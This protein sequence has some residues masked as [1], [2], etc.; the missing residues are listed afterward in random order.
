MKLFTIATIFVFILSGVF[1]NAQSLNGTKLDDFIDTIIKQNKIP[2]LSIAVDIFPVIEK[3]SNSFFYNE[4]SSGEGFMQEETKNCL[5]YAEEN[6]DAAIIL[7][8]SVLFNP[9]LHIVQQCIEK[10]LKSIIIEKS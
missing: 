10:V 3:N 1:V 8:S 7:L 6:L 9:C 5:T 2:G 4:I